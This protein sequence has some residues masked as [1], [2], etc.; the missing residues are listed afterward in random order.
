MKYYLIYF[1]Y[2]FIN[3]INNFQNLRKRKLNK[4]YKNLIARKNSLIFGMKV[5]IQKNEGKI[6]INKIKKLNPQPKF[7]NNI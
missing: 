4:H 7:I 2:F 6:K 3:K 5:I 1:I